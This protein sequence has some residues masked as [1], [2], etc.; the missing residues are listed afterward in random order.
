M[1]AA[2]DQCI[3]AHALEVELEMPQRRTL[4][5]LDTFP[6]NQ[7][8]AVDAH[9]TFAELV[10]QRFERLIQQHFT[11]LMAQGHVFVVG[12]EVDHL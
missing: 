11:G 7:R 12:N 8:V 2:D 1:A 5:L 6:G 3:L 10:F 4:Q 9:E